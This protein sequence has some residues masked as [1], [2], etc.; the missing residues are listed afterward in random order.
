MLHPPCDLFWSQ[1]S[2]A[3]QQRLTLHCTDWNE[4]QQLQ[5]ITSAKSAFGDTLAPVAINQ[6]LLFWP[7]SKSLARY[8]MMQLASRLSQPVDLYLVGENRSGVQSGIKQLPKSWGSVTKLD[9]A[10]RCSLYRVQATPLDT[11][12]HQPGAFELEFAN[13][14]LQIATLP[15][16]FS[17]QHLD[18][19]T[20]L[21]LASLQQS[22]TRATEIADIGCGC[23]VIAS[24]LLAEQPSRQLTLCDVNAMALAAARQTLQL[25]QQQAKVI[26]SDLCAELAD[27]SFDL[28]ISNPPFHP[29]QQQSQDTGLAHQLIAQAHQKLKR[30]GEL[31]IVANRF[32]A[33]PDQI[34]KIFTD[35]KVLMETNRFKVYSAV[36]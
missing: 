36:K 24:C 19:G 8:L 29:G 25:N 15:G 9:S 4:F 1:L 6:A 20:A 7:K 11:E 3:E 28:I 17:E 10:R 14:Q 33:Y 27:N 5:R 32:L 2:A 30:G 16:V 26:A 22:P 21:L 34:A 13:T 18:E 31:R 12:A 35:F 23:G